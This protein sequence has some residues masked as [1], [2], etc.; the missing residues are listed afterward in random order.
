MLFAG[1]AQGALGFGFPA[2]STPVLMLM[3]DVKTAIILNLLPNFVVNLISMLRGG[4]YRAS[5]GRYWPVAAWALLGAFL[6]ACFLIV[7]PQE[8]I[9]ILL[10]LAI[11]AYLNQHRL[12]HLDWSWL[13][14]RRRLSAMIFGVAGGFFS[15]TVNQS[16]PPLLIY[17]TLL[18]LETVVMTQI[19]NLCFIGGKTMQAATLAGAG[20]IRMS[21]ALAN[22]PLTIVSM[23]GLWL[24]IR[25][26][27]HV[28]P[29]VYKRVLRYILFV[30]AIAL[31]WQGSAWFL[32]SAHA[33]T[34]EA[35]E[36][37]KQ[38]AQSPYGAMMT[39]ILPRSIEPNE[40]PD[41][42]SAGARVMARYCVQCHY[43]P[44][45]RMHT[46]E[47]W[48][49]VVDRMVWRMRGNGNMGAVMKDMMA[50]VQAPGDDEVHTLKRYL[51]ANAQKPI[52]PSHPALKTAAG[53]MFS[54]ACSQCHAAPDPQRHT[55][56]EWPGVVARMKRHMA[57]AN[58][59]TG[60]PELRTTPELNTDAIV[61]MLQQYARR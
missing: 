14:R 46:R 16:L 27:R 25:V 30:L 54:I 10:A 24:G 49:S 41:A 39:R 59:I 28:K 36:S 9:R 18:G 23:A 32:P 8:P 50:R 44:N 6:G 40:L 26:Q 47:R 2:I 11:I 52:D 43:L 4:N 33:A 42:S 45:P 55:A 29:D 31:L 38:W 51:D 20:Q 7:A 13:A 3:V 34:T 21:D 17:F 15:G 35:E 61:R 60:A 37:Q 53:E 5:L 19:L 1:V 22:V 48:T 12:A 57:W 58:T 56:R